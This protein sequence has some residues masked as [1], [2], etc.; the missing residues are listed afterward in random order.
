MDTF[1]TTAGL[2]LRPLTPDT[3]R[4]VV[5]PRLLGPG[6]WAAEER[7]GDAFVGRFESIEGAEHGDVEY[8]LTHGEWQ[9]A[10]GCEP[11]AGRASM[12]G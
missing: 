10:E 12:A 8:A 3:V 5:L 6:Y 2:R 7:E 11:G 9:R 1:L 4:T